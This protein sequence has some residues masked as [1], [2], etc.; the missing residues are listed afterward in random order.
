MKRQK[1]IQKKNR[2]RKKIWMKRVSTPPE[3]RKKGKE[4]I[5]QENI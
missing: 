5:Q 3:E 2:K 1:K 4:C